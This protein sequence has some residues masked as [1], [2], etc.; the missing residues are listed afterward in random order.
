MF[1][2]RHFALPGLSVLAL[3]VLAPALT[4]CTASHVTPPATLH[5][6]L[7]G[8]AMGG[9]QPISGASIFLYQV[10]TTGIGSQ[11]MNLL[12]SPVTSSDG[13]GS[14]GDSSNGFNQW[15][16]GNFTL[17]GDYTCPVTDSYV[18][19]AAVGGNPGAGTNNSQ[20]SLVALGD[21]NNLTAQTY[22]TV[23]EITTVGT[24]A[25]LWPF[26][27]D[28]YST[29]YDSIGSTSGDSALAAAFNRAAEYMNSATGTAPGPALPAGFD[30]SSNDLRTLA[31]V[32]QNCVNSVSDPN[33][34]VSTACQNFFNYPENDYG[35][36]VNNTTDALDGIFQLPAADVSNIFNLAS[37]MASFQPV[38]ATPPTDWSLPIVA[39]PTA[40]AFSP[41]GGAYS[42]TQAITLSTSDNA[43]TIYYTTDGSTPTSA[44][45][46]YT[47]PF[48]LTGNTTVRAVAVRTTRVSSALSSA[49]YTVTVVP[50]ASPTF[51]PPAGTYTTT[52]NVQLSSTTANA[53]YYYTTDGSTP[54]TSSPQYTGP[55]AVPIS[56][57]IKAVA[58][59]PGYGLSPVA[60]ASYTIQ[61][62]T[63]IIS[64]V[65]GSGQRHYYGDG[66]YA[67]SAQFYAPQ[68][69]KVYNGD[70]YVADTSNGAIRK[71]NGSSGIINTLAFGPASDVAIDPTTGTVYGSSYNYISKVNTDGTTTI[72]AGTNAYASDSG[73]NGPAASAKFGG[74]Q[75]IAFDSNGN[76][77]ICEIGSSRVRVIYAAGSAVANLIHLENP[78]YTA[79]AGNIYT[80]AGTG[81][82]SF[83]GDGGLAIN[84]TFYNPTAITVDN[85]GD[86]VVADTRNY[87]IRS[88]NLSTGKIST[89]A[90][91]Q[92][93]PYN[94]ESGDGALATD[95]SVFLN[96]P[97]GV[98]YDAAGNLYISDNTSGTIRKVT[99]S[100]GFISTLATPSYNGQPQ[101]FDI[102]RSTGDLYIPL[103][104]NNTIAKVTSTGTVS[105]YAGSGA[106]D[107]RAG[108]GG[109]ALQAEMYFPEGLA[110]DGSNNMYIADSGNY[111]ILKL[112]AA[113]G[114]LTAFAGSGTQGNGNNGT[115]T[116]INLNTPHGVAVDST[117]S[118][119]YIADS[120]NYRVRKVDS[121]GNMTIFAGTTYGYSGDGGPATSAQL[122]AVWGLKVDSSN[123][124][125]I[126]DS[127]NHCVRMVS[128]SNGYISTVAGNCSTN[129]ANAGFAG[130]GHLATDSTVKLNYIQGIYLSP[131]NDLFIADNNRVRLVYNG[132]TQARTLLSAIGITGP[133][134]G[135][136][137][138]VA[139][140]GTYSSTGDGGLATAATLG[141]TFGIVTDTSGNV[142]VSTQDLTTNTANGN[143]KIRRIDVNTGVIST[144]A[145]STGQAN[146]TGDGGPA[147]SAT[148]WNPAGLALDSNG[149]LYVGDSY[150]RRVRMIQH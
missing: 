96:Y 135:Y 145:S 5:I 32:V 7:H 27:G 137:Y 103:K 122:G 97:E 31:N 14:G 78:T 117:G 60:S 111:R 105:T 59:A 80:I 113:T 127:S 1:A 81:T 24:M 110:I 19:L 34:V 109:P 92:T 8:R 54:T 93:N 28:G 83:S 94:P 84:A 15:A 74:V 42:S 116:S 33:T 3:S 16:P 136:I 150:N 25:A 90:G 41:G 89:I 141:Y 35:R 21:C 40:P 13:T 63:N 72:I 9:E 30:A 91:Y 20:V 67:T 128:A 140:T 139:G 132:G 123:N 51:T 118:N 45:N 85:S 76:L 66:V 129:S 37:P 100:S 115:A 125:Y 6:D 22:I 47:S 70:V 44:S 65:A 64:T 53:Q 114:Y 57:T 88:I 17:T 11:A 102:N 86:I 149:N 98:A 56:E 10:G 46:K 49:T 107:Y 95:S 104:N 112:T 106:G 108:L 69:V 61:P 18:Y 142:F 75:G 4:S 68:G 79:T 121:S 120:Q 82:N 130:D 133:T 146:F 119:V 36:I 50:A 2:R 126:A 101:S 48:Y 26:Y 147:Y 73:D 99:A 62:L 143:D 55:I 144:Y 38:Y 134:A 43:A 58:F 87:R 77:F 131:S 52:Q 29:S 138:T 124:V 23:N 12:N 71:I 148:L 39:V